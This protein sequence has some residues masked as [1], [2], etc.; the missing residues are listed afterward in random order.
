VVFLGEGGGI[1]FEDRK[2]PITSCDLQFLAFCF[3]GRVAGYLS[4]S[5][6]TIITSDTVVLFLIF[7][8]LKFLQRGRNAGSGFLLTLCFFVS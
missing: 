4:V 5:T 8:F 6:W 2:K 7:C 3:L 1:S